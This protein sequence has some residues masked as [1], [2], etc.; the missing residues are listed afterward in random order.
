MHC[1]FVHFDKRNFMLV[2]WSDFD[3]RMFHLKYL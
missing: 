1:N 2:F 3:L